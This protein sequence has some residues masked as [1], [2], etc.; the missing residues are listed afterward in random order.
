M[1]FVH[2]SDLHLGKKLHQLS[3]LE[4][5]RYILK[6]IINIVER[7]Q[8]DG[9]LIAGDIYDKI[10]PS[11]EAVALFDSFLV[12]LA[13]A[14][15]KIFVISG[16]HDSPERIAFLGR[17]TSLAGVYLSPVY[18]GQ[19][20]RITLED[21]FGPLNLFLL[22]FIKPVH[23]RHFYPEEEISDYTQAIQLIIRQMRLD[24][25][26]RN[27]L[28]AHQFVTGAIR[29][30]SE[31]ISVGGLDNV[32]AGV[33]K[34]FD[35][36]ALGHLHRPQS[37]TEKKIRYSGTPLKYSFSESEDN[38]SITIVE[39]KE[40]GRVEINTAALSP[41]RDV[42]K[43]QG[44]FLQLMER[45][46][47]EKTEDYVQITLWDEEDIPNAFGRLA[48]VYPGLLHLEYDN[49]RTRQSREVRVRKEHAGLS[50][51][52]LF[53]GFYEEMNNQ[54]LTEKQLDYLEEKM[55]AIWKGEIS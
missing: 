4:D 31:E 46:Q 47:K 37:V 19:I 32:A 24:K 25:G 55:E 16:N 33:F 39:L 34:D 13:K 22:P 38:K 52:E 6:E 48:L 12:E 27:L 3:L 15:R 8:A 53:A 30:E 54:P 20:D 49:M 40:K 42:V 18:N 2:I 23:V 51:R 29:S 10:Y 45:G 50:P 41:L 9:I 35:Y 44:T 14:G 43:L 11:A 28:V 21:E 7:E 5:Q 26:E 17:L 36:V 1:K